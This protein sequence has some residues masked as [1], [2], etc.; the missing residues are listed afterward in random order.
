MSATQLELPQLTRAETDP[1]PT[2]AQV[3]RL[4]EGTELLGP[5]HGSG[6]RD[7][8][9]LVRRPDGQ[10][11]LMSSL[12]YLVTTQI[13]GRRNLEAVAQAVSVASGRKLTV[14]NLS[15]LLANK[16][17]PLGVASLGGAP[18]QEGRAD[19]ILALGGRC[20]LVPPRLVRALASIFAPL[21]STVAVVVWLFAFVAVEVW[22]FA[23]LGTVA[24]SL[25]RACS[26]SPP[27]CWPT[28]AC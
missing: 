9:Y 8:R 3:P 22:T 1:E 11:I 7:D 18:A 24:E 13:D 4:I 14:P 16:L 12:L 5:F 25:S 21:F 6:F 28:S 10:T 27:T 26:S 20:V 19:P 2:D 23:S 17:V 15:L